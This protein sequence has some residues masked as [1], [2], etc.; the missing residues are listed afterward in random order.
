MIHTYHISST[1]RCYY[2]GMS[3]ESSISQYSRTSFIRILDYPDRLQ[4][5]F[6]C[7][8]IH[9]QTATPL[10]A[11]WERDDKLLR[12]V[13]TKP[14]VIKWLVLSHVSVSVLFY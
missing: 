2:V 8:I 10:A 3:H 5:P 13:P 1:S 4:Q 12:L 6:F 11:V 7:Y 14:C 9:S